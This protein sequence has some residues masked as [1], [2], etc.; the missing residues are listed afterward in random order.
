MSDPKSCSIDNEISTITSSIYAILW[1]IGLIILSI[2]AYINVKQSLQKV[3]ND[4]NAANQLSTVKTGTYVM[5]C[6]I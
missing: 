5:L 4:N 3:D 1:M 6:I 2:I